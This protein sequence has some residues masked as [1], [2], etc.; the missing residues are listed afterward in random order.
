MG[1]EYEVG[2]LN[3]VFKGEDLDGAWNLDQ[4]EGCY[5][6]FPERHG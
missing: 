1:L 5:W 3:L 6:L 2:V 4:C